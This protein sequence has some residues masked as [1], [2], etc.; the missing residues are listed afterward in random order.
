M[1]LAHD[2]A[3]E[4]GSAGNGG[5]ADAGAGSANAGGGITLNAAFFKGAMADL[6]TKGRGEWGK[7]RIAAAAKRAAAFV[8]V[9]S[10]DKRGCSPSI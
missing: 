4:N 10:R 3:L 2:R 1:L 8:Q 6:N 9:R 5:G 7:S